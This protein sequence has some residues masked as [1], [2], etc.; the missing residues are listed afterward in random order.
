[1][2]LL[3]CFSLALQII[4]LIGLFVEDPLRKIVFLR[5]KMEWYDQFNCDY[6]HLN[7]SVID[8]RSVFKIEKYVKSSRDC[9]NYQFGRA[10]EQV[11]W[12]WQNEN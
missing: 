11:L 9:F 12:K 6:Q 5:M 1:M 3:A 8:F 4:I 7:I 10:I 2:Y